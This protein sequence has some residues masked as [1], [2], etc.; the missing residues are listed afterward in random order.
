MKIRIYGG[1][2]PRGKTTIDALVKANRIDLIGNILMGYNPGGRMYAALA[3][4]AMQ[5]KGI[6]L[7]PDV[8]QALQVV[9]AMD[10][11]LETC[12]GCIV[13]HKTAKQIISDWPF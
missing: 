3:F 6:Q 2:T 12:D 13:S 10:L 11:E 9:R 8:I 1:V 5:R 4:I 7:S